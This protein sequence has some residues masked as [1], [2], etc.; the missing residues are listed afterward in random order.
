[1]LS[2]LL[3]KY[4]DVLAHTH[5]LTLHVGSRD[6][7]RTL[8]VQ[9]MKNPFHLTNLHYFGNRF[10]AKVTLLIYLLDHLSTGSLI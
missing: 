4:R 10:V 9:P 7:D 3:T 2:S 6:T 8:V 5:T 1:M